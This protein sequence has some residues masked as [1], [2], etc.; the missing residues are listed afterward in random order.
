VFIGASL[1]GMVSTIK[2]HDKLVLR[3]AEVYDVAADGML[4]AELKPID[5]SGTEPCPQLALGVGLAT[6]QL[7]GIEA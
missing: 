5:L 2:L 1:A 6:S 3:A 7:P 4:A